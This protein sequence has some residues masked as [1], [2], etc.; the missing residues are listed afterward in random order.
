LVAESEKRADTSEGVSRVT[1][2]PESLSEGKFQDEV[3][4][5][6]EERTVEPEREGWGLPEGDFA[7]RVKNGD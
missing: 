3:P 1:A 7:S 4:P 2:P 6:G 5:G